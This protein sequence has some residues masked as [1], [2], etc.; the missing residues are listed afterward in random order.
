MSIKKWCMGKIVITEFGKLET[1]ARY[2]EWSQ[3][4]LNC[5][6]KSFNKAYR[7]IKQFYTHF[8]GHHIGLDTHDPYDDNVLKERTVFTIEP[9]LYFNKMT[10]GFAIPEEYYDL[11]G[12]RIEDMYAI[13]KREGSLQLINLSIDIPKK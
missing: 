6:L 12:V 10:I 7:F 1:D 3:G 13:L 5:K 2:L 9:G 4:I 11:G 8:I